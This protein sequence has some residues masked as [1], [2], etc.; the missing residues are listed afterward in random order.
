MQTDPYSIFVENRPCKVAFFVAPNTKFELLD[1]I[2]RYNRRLWGG[3]FN[4]V[5][6]TDGED[7]DP[8][9][10]SFLR[11]Y[12]PDFVKATL[13]L[14]DRLRKKIHTF[15]SPLEV[16]LHHDNGTPLHLTS[17]PLALLPN[18]AA[19]SRV[20][21]DFFDLESSLVLFEPEE[22][23][24]AVIRDFLDRNFGLMDA[25]PGGLFEVKQA[26]R[27]VKAQ[28]YPIGSLE[29]LSAALFELGD[30]RRV[31]FPSQLCSEP[32]Y[33]PEINRNPGSDRFVI[34]VGD[35]QD[36]LIHFW[37]R[38]AAVPVWLRTSFT[39][40]WL[41]TELARSPELRAGL[42]KFLTRFVGS[43]GN[44]S[45]QGVLFLTC[46][47]DEAAI[48]AIV[49][50]LGAK[51]P[52]PREG[53]R[54]PVPPRFGGSYATRAVPLIKSGLDLYRGHSTEEYLVLS[55][56]DRATAPRG[57]CWF[58]DVYVQYRPERFRNISGTTYWWQLPAR[59]RL[60]ADS[61]FF[62]RA[63][64]VK[65]NGFFSVLMRRTT[66]FGSERG[67]LV[68][69]IPDDD[70]VAWALICGE[71][72]DHFDETEKIARPFTTTRSSDKG[73]TLAGVLSLFP[74]L[75][76]A[77][78]WFQQR[79]WRRIFDQMSNQSDA[80]DDARTTEVYNALRKHASEWKREEKIDDKLKLLAKRAID[81]AKTYSL[82][83]IDL[84]FADFVDSA[85]VEA[86]DHNALNPKE[87]LDI[88]SDKAKAGLQREMKESVSGLIEWR[89]LLS[90][91]KPKCP[92]CGF[93]IWYHIN[94]AS[95]DITCNGC[96][97][98]YALSAEEPWYY[99][100]NSLVRAAVARL[101]TIPVLLVIGQLMQDARSSFIFVPPTDLLSDVPGKPLSYKV[102]GD[103][104][105]VCLVD[106]KFVI[107]EVK[108]STNLF[109]AEVFNNVLRVARMIK[110][111]R[112]LFS[113]LEGQDR[114]MINQ[115]IKRLGS[116]LAALEV[117][118]EWYPLR[119]WYTDPSPL[120]WPEE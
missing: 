22:G 107:G 90:G 94:H 43:T 120:R 59:N 100:L 42:I 21:R 19:V 7:I 101:G 35:T 98:R 8:E 37:N 30:Y 93:R 17:E 45:S 1:E 95:Q 80:K 91:F 82:D 53:A 71:P 117:S 106:G 12:D 23:V 39:Q 20:A 113:A 58:A 32:N 67:A 54:I 108:K 86:Q 56:V 38:A 68:V 36:E 15:L 33:P 79:L 104:D 4:P 75:L 10:W 6:V 112:V 109:T 87:V 66:G 55:E 16:E 2:I 26:L 9:W 77:D 28:R 111:D 118:V 97:S 25:G 11:E 102:E 29:A 63:A 119:K 57:D 114:P 5:I 73:Q 50:D 103:L 116:E 74:D 64:R 81:I 60:L 48:N 99:Q 84:R 72:F 76:N 83:A 92:S 14:S 51:I 96:G 31:V 115:N 46:S 69:R 110:P 40:M 44:Q 3:R 78:H 24:P 105:I 47:L 85:I 49:A 13:P 62:N 88:S 18:K 89:V 27:E 52:Y 61:R 34:L 41:P 65:Q 70:T